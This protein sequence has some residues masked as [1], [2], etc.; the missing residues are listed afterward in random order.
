M[1]WVSKEIKTKIL[2]AVENEWIPVQ[3]LSE[4]YGVSKVSIYAW[5]KEKGEKIWS[6]NLQELKRLKRD[7]EDLLI[8]IWELTAELNKTKKKN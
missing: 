7:K 3:K 2:N 1:S 8:I 5:I 6:Y 4:E